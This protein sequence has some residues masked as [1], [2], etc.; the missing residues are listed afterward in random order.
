MPSVL[1]AN[2]IT[3]PGVYVSESTAGLI[4]AALASFNRAY[5]I[6]TAATGDYNKPSQVIN[7]EDAN[8]QFGITPSDESIKLFFRNH[9]N[10]LLFFV[11][12]GAPERVDAYITVPDNEAIAGTYNLTINGTAFTYTVAIAPGA[13]APTWQQLINA[14]CEE[15]NIATF[16]PEV[17]ATPG[18]DGLIRLEA[19]TIGD[20][21]T[22]AAGA[23]PVG[24]EAD[25]RYFVHNL[26]LAGTDTGAWSVDINDT[27]VTYTAAG[28][29]TL[30]SI[31]Q[32]LAAAIEASAIADAVV[33]SNITG[34]GFR[35]TA[36]GV[37]TLSVDNP[38]A[39]G[40]GSIAI[41]SDAEPPDYAQFIYTLEHAFDPELDEQGFILCPEA[42]QNLTN[43]G[44][45]TSVALI[46]ENVAATESYDWMAL[47]DSGPHT[48][49]NNP[50][51][52]RR[53]GLLYTTPRGHLAY[54]FPYLLTVEDLVVPPS[55]A[56]AAIALRRYADQGF[57]QPPAGA[58]YPV[59]GVKD[60][61]VRVVKAQQAAINPLGI[62]CIRYFPNQGTLVWGSRTRS[63]NPYYRFINTRVIL[64]VL[65]GTLRGAFDSV[66][67]TAVDGQGVLFSRIRETAYAICY[68]LWDGGAFYGATPQEAFFCKCDRE[69]NPALD[70]E[71]GVVRLDV[72][73]V[74]APTLERLLISVVRTA[75]GQI[76]VVTRNLGA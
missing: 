75:I 37:T 30:A 60:A 64:N 26:T 51:K 1:N 2:I 40:A 76:E 14:I 74:P 3:A 12:V 49:I 57:I 19:A 6:G 45:R 58:Q 73:V 27:T 71:D 29:P 69:N 20:N 9:I 15:I 66:I 47:T 43:Q 31:V 55:A 68:R 63:G 42:F 56:V 70:L 65:I 39:P 18:T 41:A 4:P 72:Y 8:N 38:D 23:M 33:V 21:L 13:T 54:F 25:V 17:V 7:L 53:E 52:A 35:L 32:G 36:T 16:T 61:V 10:G 67:F 11:R 22:V 34:T 46:M 28:T 59:K 50:D 44:Q 62:N 24:V 48:E 5:M